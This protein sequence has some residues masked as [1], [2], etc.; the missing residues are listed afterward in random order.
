[1]SEIELIKQIRTQTGLS[2]KDIKNAIAATGSDDVE[3][4]ITYLREQ[5]ALKANARQDRATGNGRIFSYVHEGRI[6]IMIEIRSETDFVSRGEVFA[7]LGKDLCLHAAANLPK[8]L[9]ADEVDQNFIDKEIE[10]A[11][12]QL[13]GEGKP[14]EMIEKILDGKKKK[15]VEEVSM[16]SQPFFKDTSRTVESR[17]LEVSQTT[18]EKIEVTK[19]VTMVL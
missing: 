18:G 2:L 10:I 13:E 19:L 9:R 6:G 3:K 14:A 1:M 11:K 8:F 15:I 5:G 12:V 4:I 7:D 16:L 17:V